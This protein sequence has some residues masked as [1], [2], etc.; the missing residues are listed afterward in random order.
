MCF[1]CPT[2][3]VTGPSPL[4]FLKIKMESGTQDQHLLFGPAVDADAEQAEW[5]APT[6]AKNQTEEMKGPTNAQ[7]C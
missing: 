2:H 5:R 1:T 3:H 7:Q 6:M 4:L